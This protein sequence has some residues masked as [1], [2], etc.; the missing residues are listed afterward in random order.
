MCWVACGC[1][2][3]PLSKWCC[4]YFVDLGS[5]YCCGIVDLQMRY[6]VEVFLLCRCHTERICG[7]V[8]P[9]ARV[10]FCDLITWNFDDLDFPSILSWPTSKGCPCNVYGHLPWCVAINVITPPPSSPNPCG[11]MDQLDVKISWLCECISWW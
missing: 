1:A 2:P 5:W 3:P 4:T 9:F 7:G 8:T 10:E 11:L 6:T